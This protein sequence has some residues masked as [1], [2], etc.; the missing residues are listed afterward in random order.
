MIAGQTHIRYWDFL[1]AYLNDL[2]NF[3]FVGVVALAIG[4]T[5]GLV[6]YQNGSGHALQFFV[7][8]IVVIFAGAIVYNAVLLFRAYR[9]MP[10]EN[11]DVQLTVDNAGLTM[12]DRAGHTL[13]VPWQNYRK[14]R[15]HPK[16]WL[17]L[18]KD[19]DC[20]SLWVTR[21]FFNA[22]LGESFEALA[23][24]KLNLRT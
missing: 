19:K 16:G 12:R 6:Q 8:P 20:P 23:R 5:G 7:F 17:L 11:R 18:H 2:G 14:I 1:D 4:I 21:R 9:K 3:E 24:E 22:E 15:V 13:T 10:S